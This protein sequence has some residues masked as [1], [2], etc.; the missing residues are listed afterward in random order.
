MKCAHCSTAVRPCIWTRM[1]REMCL[2]T[3]MSFFFFSV[4]TQDVSCDEQRQ[5]AEK[6]GQSN[7]TVRS[8]IRVENIGHLTVKAGDLAQLQ[9]INAGEESNP[10]RRLRK[11]ERV[12]D[13]DLVAVDDRKR[14]QADPIGTRQLHRIAALQTFERRLDI[15]RAEQLFFVEFLDGAFDVDR[16]ALR[17]E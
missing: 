14:F 11:R 5:R 9:Q 6:I 7:D 10:P 2:W 8:T 16:R 4:S 12:L 13:D 1:S 17:P 3:R 15:G